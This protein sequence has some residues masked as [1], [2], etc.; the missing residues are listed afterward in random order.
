MRF[1]RGCCI[2]S[3]HI[4]WTK[5]R[6]PERRAFSYFLKTPKGDD[7]DDDGKQRTGGHRESHGQQRVGKQG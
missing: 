4:R 2:T 1:V 7:T 6:I 5:M 3:I